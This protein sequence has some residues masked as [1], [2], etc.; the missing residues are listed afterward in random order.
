MIGLIDCNNFFV[1]CERVFNP[2][3]Q[4]EP[5]IVLSNNDGCVVSLSNEAKVLN[6]KRGVPLSQIQSIVDK[7]GVRVYSSNYK[8]YGDMSTRVMST[9]MTIIPNIE[10]YSIDEAFIDLSDIPTSKIEDICRSIVRKIRRHTGIPTSLGVA[11]TKTLAKIASKIAKCDAKNNGVFIISED[12]RIDILKNTS[13]DA[14]WGI[15]K[16][17]CQRLYRIGISNAFTFIQNPPLSYADILN[18]QGI[19]IWHELNGKPSIDL[20]GADI[21]RKQ[22][23]S[24][25]TFSVPLTSIDELYSAISMFVENICNKLVKQN[26][27]AVSINVFLYS[28][29]KNNTLDYAKNSYYKFEEPTYDIV[30]IT[31]IALSQVKTL[32]KVGLE[33]KKAGIIIPE[34]IKTNEIQPCLFSN[35]QLRKKHSLLMDT[36]ANINKN[37]RTKDQVHL[38]TISSQRNLV[39]NE[40]QSPL[41]TTAFDDIIKI[42]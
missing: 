5:V 39:K 12:N 19:K 27:C 14:I 9:L 33:Y 38:A 13:I 17:L 3:L 24:S 4:N 37:E 21:D 18:I 28:G 7:N 16:Q 40:Y 11:P 25:R 8:L 34:I 26:S 32:F 22:L 31:K 6:I 20:E 36:L 2:S 42:N 41:Y 30:T 29:G 15:G 10:I 35:H 23:C 1:S